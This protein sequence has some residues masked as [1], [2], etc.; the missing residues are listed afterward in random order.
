[1]NEELFNKSPYL[2]QYAEFI[3]R[4]R[5]FLKQYDSY[6]QAAGEA[7]RHCIKNGILTDFLKKEGGVQ[8]NHHPAR[9]ISQGKHK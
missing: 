3:A 7:V 6:S 2:R 4:L 9:T 5:E 8:S 1:M